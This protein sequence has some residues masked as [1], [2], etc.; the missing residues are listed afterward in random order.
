[1]G[2]DEIHAD[3]AEFETMLQKIK[4]AGITPISLHRVQNWPMGV[5]VLSDI[6]N[7]V[8]GRIDSFVKM[9]DDQEPFSEV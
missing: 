7:Y 3:F 1:M 8:G 5:S 2:Y 9:S 4:G 6:S